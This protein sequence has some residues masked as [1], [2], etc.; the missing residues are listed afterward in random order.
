MLKD[1]IDGKMDY[2]LVMEAD[3]KITLFIKLSMC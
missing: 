1:E 2:S 3:A